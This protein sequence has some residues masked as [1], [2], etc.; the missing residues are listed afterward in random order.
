MEALQRGHDKENIR[1]KVRTGMLKWHIH[2]SR[3]VTRILFRLR[4]GHN[5]LGAHLA[6][7]FSS[8]NPTCQECEQHEE[9]IDHILLR[10]PA[11]EMER[12]P[13]SKFFTENRLE[14]C[15]T[16]LLGLNLNL[17]STNQYE[18]QR[19]LTRYLKETQLLNRI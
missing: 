16:N 10:C 14:H 6:R 12:E 11:L 3:R 13:I 17:S 9:T 19:L 7:F 1:N 4:T 2:K 5:R 18:I 8:H 15:T